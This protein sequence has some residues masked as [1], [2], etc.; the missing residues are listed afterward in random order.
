MGFSAYIE[1]LVLALA[2]CQHNCIRWSRGTEAYGAKPS[3]EQ[4][5]SS[6]HGFVYVLVVCLQQEMDM[7]KQSASNNC[8]LV[9]FLVSMCLSVCLFVCL[10]ICLLF[11]LLTVCLSCFV[12][13][14]IVWLFVVVVVCLLA[15]LLVG[16]SFLFVFWFSLFVKFVG[17]CFFCMF[18]M[19]CF[20]AWLVVFKCLFFQPASE[21]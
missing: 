1:G 18:V 2:S 8:K 20:F 12:R 16:L 15:C 14:F 3:N 11:V 17:Q 21:A 10:F 4:I 9:R 7:S 19:F 6:I 5:D 13:V